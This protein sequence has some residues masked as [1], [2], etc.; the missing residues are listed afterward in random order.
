M[1]VT[2]WLVNGKQIKYWNHRHL[3]EIDC[4]LAVVGGLALNAGANQY[5]CPAYSTKKCF[6][7]AVAGNITTT[8][9]I[10]WRAGP[11]SSLLL[12]DVCD[13]NQSFKLCCL[14]V[15]CETENLNN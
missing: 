14:P 13:W 3:R 4:S 11:M 15:T 10:G 1:I 2:L 6:I 7:A 9:N 5:T 8:E 12:L